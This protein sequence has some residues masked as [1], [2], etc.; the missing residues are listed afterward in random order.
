MTAVSFRQRKYLSIARSG[1]HDPQDQDEKLDQKLD[2]HR[3]A[4][5]QVGHESIHAHTVLTSA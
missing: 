4:S 1:G 3:F 5:M 2:V